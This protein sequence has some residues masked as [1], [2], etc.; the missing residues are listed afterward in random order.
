MAITPKSQL[1]AVAKYQS[2]LKR[3]TVCFMPEK[4]DD[5]LQAIANDEVSFTETV[6]NCLREH[7][8]LAKNGVEYE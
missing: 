8:K 3:M 4:D 5:L 7:Y 1:E 2:K 6:K